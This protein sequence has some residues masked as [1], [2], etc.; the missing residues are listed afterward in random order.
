M[1]EGR[2]SIRSAATGDLEAIVERLCEAYADDPFFRWMVPNEESW[3]AFAHDYFGLLEPRALRAEQTLVAGECD[4]VAIW[5]PPGFRLLE[6]GDLM[7]LQRLLAEHLGDRTSLGLAGLLAARGHEPEPEHVTLVLLAV[8]AG[9]QGLGIGGDLLE[10][11]LQRL[12]EAGLGAY[13]VSTNPRNLGFYAR[14]GFELRAAIS[15]PD[16][17]IS[18]QAMWREPGERRAGSRRRKRRRSSLG[19]SPVA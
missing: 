6:A 8:R 3:P 9:L 16:G 18:T 10:P 14:A 4:A 19:H 12:D 1:I 11:T 13:L 15:T 2:R 17:A 7:R 5:T